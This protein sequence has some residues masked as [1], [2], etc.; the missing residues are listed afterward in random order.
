M[1]LCPITHVP[2]FIVLGTLSIA[3]FD[4]TFVFES[5]LKDGVKFNFFFNRRSFDRGSRSITSFQH[6]FYFLFPQAALNILSHVNNIF[7]KGLALK[8]PDN[9]PKNPPFC[10]FVSFLNV[11]VI[12]L[13]KL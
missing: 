1:F 12:Q 9:I 10:S 3:H 6:S 8:V 5:L 7:P 11:L 13:N 2:F 4:N